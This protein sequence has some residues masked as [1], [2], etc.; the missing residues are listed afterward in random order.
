LALAVAGALAIVFWRRPP[1]ESTGFPIPEVALSRFRNTRSD[2]AYVGSAACRSCHAGEDASFRRTGMGRSMAFVDPAAAPPDGVFD[3]PV[4]KRRYRVYRQDGQ[5]W[6]RESL[7]A[8]G[9]QEVVLNDV[10]LKHV[11]GS[12][13][14][15]QTF[16]AEIDGFLVESPL[17][18]YA[19]RKAWSMSPGYDRAEHAGFQRAVGETC[20]SCHAGQ[21]A[22]EGGSV[23]R[24]RIDE[25]ALSC[26]RCHG[27][28]ALHVERHSKSLPSGDD[29]AALDDTIVNPSRLSRE[30]AEAVCGQCHLRAVATV[31]ARGRKPSGFRPGLPLEDFRHDYQFETAR[32]PV[33]VV[34]H[35]EQMH[36]SRCYQ[37]SAT[38]TCT[39]C[40]DPHHEPPAEK[41]DAH[42]QAICLS[43]H[44]PAQ[45]TVAP[46]RRVKESPANR[47]VQCHMPRATTE[48]PHVAFTHHRIGVHE[49]SADANEAGPDSG[50]LQPFRELT[51]LG[52]IDRKRSLGLAYAEAAMR[53]DDLFNAQR[54][55]E[56]AMLLLTEV[57]NAGLRD[58]YVDASLTK[59]RAKMHP[60]EVL[61][62]A[63]SALA[64][65][66]LAGPERGDV[67][68]LRADALARQGNFEAA[69][70]TLHD[71]G[72]LRR[73]ATDWLVLADCRRAQGDNDAAIAA[74][75]AAVRINPRLWKVQRRLA[76]HYRRLGDAAK[77]AWHEQRAAP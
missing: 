1:G 42:Y 30:L 39:T 7:L 21:A 67:M 34:G 64:H 6:H 32:T 33:K 51:R 77:A 50:N 75:E 54:C 36:L 23:H 70:A 27:P 71:L 69:V 20:L 56:K 48:V 44:Q 49:P 61:S 65:A 52:E 3:H 40:H 41:A 15:A 46:D 14:H 74:F 68:F 17:T 19:A 62:L 26:E 37:K 60:D 9:T 53:E 66:E 16:L 57:R 22:A 13:R 38:M 43:C 11:V 47:C 18:W 25:A 28:G 35:V 8:G 63:E 2:V 31:P 45:C 4:S 76:E 72:R 24:M 55:A 58:A 12:G 29:E 73:S 59:L 10:P 5:V